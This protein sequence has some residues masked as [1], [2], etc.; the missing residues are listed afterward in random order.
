LLEGETFRKCLERGPLPWRKVVQ[1]GV[2][3]AEGLAMAH[4]RGIIHRDLKPENLFLTADNRVKILDFGLARMEPQAPSGAETGPYQPADTD[5]GIVLGTVGYMSPEQLRGQRIDARSDLFALGCVLYEMV[6]GRRA[7]HAAS[8]SEVQAAILRDDPPLLADA[9]R[10]VPAGLEG[11]I[12]CCLEKQP[13]KRFSS[14]SDLAVELRA[15]LNHSGH[16]TAP[17]PRAP[18]APAIHRGRPALGIAAAILLV[19]AIGGGAGWYA[20]RARTGKPPGSG[21]S[22]NPSPSIVAVAILPFQYR[23]SDPD[24]EV[25]GDGISEIVINSLSPL[26][27]LKVRP[28]S[29]VT[30]YKGQ[31]N[32]DVKTVGDDL[33]VQAVFT[34]HVE[35]QG[36]RLAV[37]VALVDLRDDSQ[38]WG[39]RYTRQ[40]ADIF[41]IQEDIARQISAKLRGQLTGEEE[42]RVAKRYTNDPQAYELYLRGRHFLNTSINEDGAKRAIASFQQ[43]VKRDP[44]YALAY[45][46]IAEAHYWLSNV[47]KAPTEVIP[48]AKKALREALRIDDKLGEAHAL[49]GLFL[50]VFD[51]DYPAAEAEFRQAVE[52]SPG[53]ATAHLYYGL[54]L[55]MVG[56][57]VDAKAEMSRARELDPTS[58]Y[59]VAYACFGLYLAHEYNQAIQDLEELLANDPKSFLAHAYLGLCYEQQGEFDKAVASLCKATELDDNLEAKAQLGHAYALAGRRQEALKLLEKLTDPSRNRYVSPYNI[60]LIHLGL[61]DTNEAF[62]WLDKAV[63]DHSE[64]IVMLGTDPR[65]KPLRAD[66][67]FA[68]LAQRV[69]V[70]PIR[71]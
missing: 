65:L 61:G 52:W 26:R 17:V 21:R 2:D 71:D 8:A 10:E 32:L 35:R 13:E 23:E 22:D 5:T 51:W 60:A 20:L 66:P 54:Y 28:F 55:N 1:V 40:F 49:M 59:L 14:A 34:G 63:A 57:Y 6:S 29:A 25:L 9:G 36:D 3:I 47:Y 46:G 4:A 70:G 18:P 45:A 48:D 11:V 30:R 62:A 15:L 64:W 42:Q 43:A 7:F 39:Q 41:S 67:R 27:N 16:S 12:R 19:L 44:D 68:R 69:K 31:K 53:S 58:Q 24:A 38:L 37:N 50:A 33:N 56:R